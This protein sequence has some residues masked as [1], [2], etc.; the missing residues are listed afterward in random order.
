MNRWSKLCLFYIL[1]L[2]IA[3]SNY[4]REEKV[5][6]VSELYTSYQ[7]EQQHYN[8]NG[9]EVDFPYFV[10]GADKDTLVEWNRIIAKDLKKILDIYS[11]N[12]FPMAVPSPTGTIPVILTVKNVIKKVGDQYFSVFYTAAYNSKYSAHPTELVYT[13]NI[14][15]KAANRIALSDLVRIDEEFVRDFRNWEF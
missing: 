12:P 10:S 4:F 2:I 15:L 9:I 6:T 14:D 3:M 5:I 13:T 11:F 7:I 1:I 8:K